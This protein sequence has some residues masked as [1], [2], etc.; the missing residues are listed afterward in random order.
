MC[1]VQIRQNVEDL[2]FLTFCVSWIIFAVF[3]GVGITFLYMANKLH[4]H[5]VYMEYMYTYI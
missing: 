4:H 1:S 5:R 2:T 3:K